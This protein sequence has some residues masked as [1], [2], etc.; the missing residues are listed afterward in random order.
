M[1]TVFRQVE[2]VLTNA[3][4]ASTWAQKAADAAKTLSDAEKKALAQDIDNAKTA[5]QSAEASKT[6]AN[7]I[8]KSI[9]QDSPIDSLGHQVQF[10]VV[11]TV[12]ATPSWALWNFKGPGASGNFAS[13]TDTRT[14]TLN[15][16]LGAPAGAVNASPE[17]ERML[18]NLKLD[19]LRVPPN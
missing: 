8:W 14:H 3:R 13:L 18:Q 17:Q 10:I 7:A 4:D 9:P 15:I 16:A 11:S 19:T 5:G 1:Q 12:N 6:A 2:D